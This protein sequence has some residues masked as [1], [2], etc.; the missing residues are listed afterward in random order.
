MFA[1]GRPD[2]M[3]RLPKGSAMSV[4]DEI[5]YPR[6]D[7][8][9]LEYVLNRMEAAASHDN[10]AEHGYARARQDLLAG[11]LELRWLKIAPKRLSALADAL[12]R[13]IPGVR[14]VKVG[15]G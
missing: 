15:R 8:D 3:S 1:R 6:A 12:R 2:D 4:P 10:P 7:R 14:K 13:P 11:I 9:P 5:P